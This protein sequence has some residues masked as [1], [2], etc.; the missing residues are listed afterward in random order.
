M[1]ISTRFAPSPTGALHPGSLRTALFSWLFAR[2]RGGRFLIRIEDTDAERSDLG[3]A[4][5]QLADLRWLGLEHDETPVRQ[6]DRQLE[7]IRLLDTLIDANRVYR[8]FCSKDRLEA[9]RQAQTRKGQPPRY[10]GHCRDLDAA[11]SAER[12]ASG[13]K[14]V[15]RLKTFSVGDLRLH[16]LVRGE[17]VF[18]VA[19]IGDFVLTREDGSPV[20]L[21]ANAIDDSDMGIT[22]VLRGDD[23]L[24][25][26]PRQM[27]VLKAL[28][29]PVPVYGHLPL[30][31]DEH[32]RPL[33]KR[34][35]SLSIAALREQGVLPLALANLLF[36][37]GHHETSG[38][39]MEMGQLATRF[40]PARLGKAAA[41]FDA[42]QL[43]HWQALALRDL[44]E[45]TYLD[46]ARGCL[47]DD[48]V[49]DEALLHLVRSNIHDAISLADAVAA[50]SGTLQ[51]DDSACQAI[52]GATSDFYDQALAQLPSSDQ[53]LSG[54]VNSVRE[55]SGLK[56]K[57][58]F[59][60]IRAA[61]TGRTDGPELASILDYL[62]T[63]RIRQRLTA[64]QG[65]STERD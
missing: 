51:P 46:W 9:L 23:H 24:S 54:W 59:M 6:S 13:T 17:I 40:D 56:G 1:A 31:T 47:E 63:D 8:C 62:G 28:E 14:S 2:G 15:W 41:R 27:L 36:R 50:L 4:D 61:L 12:L 55:A 49:A 52:A 38:E 25:N 3:T 34:D 60:P 39:L 18:P 57:A 20:F 44:D 5:Q 29:R 48:V 42:G 64:A 22:H 33:S 37:L 58:L 45:A 32:A 19:D 53:D 21:F 65:I 30:V 43:A 10:D 7:H 35:A 16:D 11:T 26:T